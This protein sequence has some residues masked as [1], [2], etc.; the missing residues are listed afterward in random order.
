MAEWIKT[1]DPTTY[2]LQETHFTSMD[3]Y[4][5]KVKE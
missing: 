2:F 5:V 1:P 4:R 3:T